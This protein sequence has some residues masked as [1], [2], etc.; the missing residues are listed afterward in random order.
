MTT[1]SRQQRGRGIVNNRRQVDED[2]CRKGQ[3]D[4]K[5]SATSTKTIYSVLLQIQLQNVLLQI[6]DAR[7]L[8]R[9]QGSW[10]QSCLWGWTQIYSFPTESESFIQSLGCFQIYFCWIW[11][12]KRFEYYISGLKKVRYQQIANLSN[13][14]QS[15]VAYKPN[16]PT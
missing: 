2:L 9:H 4:S 10:Q 11:D 5:R 1:R 16:I 15:H 14:T 8:L 13:I 7:D 12:Y 6:E 3:T